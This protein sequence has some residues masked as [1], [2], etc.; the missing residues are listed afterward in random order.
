MINFG[1]LELYYAVSGTT[2]NVFQP[3]SEWGSGSAPPTLDERKAQ[4]LLVLLAGPAVAT[5]FVFHG[6]MLAFDESQF[7]RLHAL[8]DVLTYPVTVV[9]KFANASVTLSSAADVMD[10]TL[11]LLIP[12]QIVRTVVA[13][14]CLDV[15]A[16]TSNTDIDV[17]IAAA[18]SDPRLATLPT[19]TL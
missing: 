10:L 5:Q 2:E 9:G 16:A 18:V 12:A 14:L 11:T 19:A 13:E 1:K 8:R 6:V 17:A 3:L 4:I 7:L 15:A